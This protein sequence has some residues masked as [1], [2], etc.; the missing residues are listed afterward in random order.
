MSVAQNPPRRGSWHKLRKS[1]VYHFFWE[2]SDQSICGM[3]SRLGVPKNQVF[4]LSPNA[5]ISDT[6]MHCR[7]AKKS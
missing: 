5:P 2:D 4:D 7:R 1:Y 3:V 6:C